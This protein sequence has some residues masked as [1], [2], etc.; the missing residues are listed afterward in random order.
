[1]ENLQTRCEYLVMRLEPVRLKIVGKHGHQETLEK[2][3]EVEDGEHRDAKGGVGS[4][5]GEKSE[6]NLGTEA[7][8]I[9]VPE[10]TSSLEWVPGACMELVVRKRRPAFGAN[11]D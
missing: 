10:G 7:E 5:V 4:D 9:R 1:M 2:G 11:S 6:G 3:Y 8:S